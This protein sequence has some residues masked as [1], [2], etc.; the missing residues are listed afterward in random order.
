MPDETA[1]RPLEVLHLI[2]GLGRGGA[3]ML[4]PS[5]IRNGSNGYRYSV[6][7][8][9][10]WKDALVSELRD[11][12]VR[13]EHYSARGPIGMLARVPQLARSFRRCG[14]DIVH[15]HL[16]LAGVVAR[17]A[18]RMSG[19]PVVYTEHNL[20]E[21]YHRATRAANLGTWK[22]QS[23]VITV[24][25]AVANSARSAAGTSVPITVMNNGVD[26][27]R[28]TRRSE[29]SDAL[30]ARLEIP[31]AAPV[32]GTVAVFRQQKRLDL[33]LEVALRLC[34]E[35][36][37]VRFLIVGDGV[38]RGEL[39]ELA[40]ALGLDSRTHFAG[41]QQDVR[42]Y[43]QAMDVYLM[44]SDFEGL[45]VAL[46]EAMATGLA[47][48]TTA[49]GGIPAVIDDGIS[50]MMVEPGDA[51][52]LAS[53]VAALLSDRDRIEAMGRRARERVEGHF[54]ARAMA[55]GIEGIYE[56]IRDSGRKR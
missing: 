49:V 25:E 8:F 10:P 35:H 52:A 48:V 12:G 17:L 26:I 6:G 11:M 29:E 24:S 40:A 28:F 22:L 56:A 41:L 9:L 37:G 5:L 44:S 33:W 27:E 53:A 21:H 55:E 19:V 15:A 20:M 30:R 39:E 42:P 4:L 46:L 50:G 54:S 51:T 18:G 16:P 3:E 32:V 36:E 47:C 14:V 34:R 13:V 1:D 31:A 23:S 45:P 2:K 43:L 7:Y 38:L